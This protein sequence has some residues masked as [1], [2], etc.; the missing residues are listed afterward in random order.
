MGWTG[1]DEP[2]GSRPTLRAYHMQVYF[3]ANVT[4]KML[5]VPNAHGQFTQDRILLCAPQP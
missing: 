4:P 2:R 1:K 3:V 5:Q